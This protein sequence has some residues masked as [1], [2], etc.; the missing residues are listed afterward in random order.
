MGRGPQGHKKSG[1]NHLD[2]ILRT[3]SLLK[4]A[5]TALRLFIG[6]QGIPGFSKR[7]LN[8]EHTARAHERR[9]LDA[10][11]KTTDT[12]WRVGKKDTH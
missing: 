11:Q 2:S 1:L 6:Y 5:G 4:I 9:M 8:N 12:L 10:T 7:R 3:G